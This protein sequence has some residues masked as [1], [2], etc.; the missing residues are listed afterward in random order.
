MDII[1]YPGWKYMLVK[2]GTGFVWADEMYIILFAVAGGLAPSHDYADIYKCCI[3][4][5]D[6]WTLVM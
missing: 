2:E 6:S 5:Y 3:F 4:R 1:T